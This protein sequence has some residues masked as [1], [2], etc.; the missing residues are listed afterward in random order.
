MQRF[1]PDR[2]WTLVQHPT[3]GTIN[4]ENLI[5]SPSPP[6]VGMYCGDVET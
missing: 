1:R 4:E 6:F 3:F 5:E 2:S